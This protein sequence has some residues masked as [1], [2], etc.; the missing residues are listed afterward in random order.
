MK[1]DEFVEIVWVRLEVTAKTLYN[2]VGGYRRYIAP[3]LGCHSIT[4]ITSVDLRRCLLRLPSQTRYQTH[5]MLR[6]IFREALLEGL[7]EKNPMSGLKTPRVSPKPSKFLTWD[8]LMLLDFGSHTNRIRF[9]ALHG[10][11]Y[12]EAAALTESDIYDGLVHINKSIHGQT[13]TR[14]G[15]RTVPYLGYYEKFPLKQCKLAAKLRPYGVTVHSLRKTYAYSLK[16]SN[17][18]VTTAARLLGHANPMVTLKIYTG[19]RDDEISA[20]R[21]LLIN[22]LRLSVKEKAVM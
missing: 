9:L 5:M 20:S 6:T 4:D 17:V 7:I 2:Y 8:E 13:K 14:A 10:L 21:D 11:R 15:V 16:S 19:V 12:G 18:H 1:L 22:T 3:E